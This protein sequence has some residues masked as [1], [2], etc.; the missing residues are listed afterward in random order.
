M[1]KLKG[2]VMHLAMVTLVLVMELRFVI[3]YLL[4]R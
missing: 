3:E 1:V 4:D 2:M